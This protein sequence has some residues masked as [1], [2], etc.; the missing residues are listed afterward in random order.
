[1]PT[2]ICRSKNENHAKIIEFRPSGGFGTDS[3][4]SRAR[5]SCPGAVGRFSE[6]FILK[7]ILFL[8]ILNSYILFLLTES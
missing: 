3:R 2:K 4:R 5:K 1:M 7:I 6:F 8:D